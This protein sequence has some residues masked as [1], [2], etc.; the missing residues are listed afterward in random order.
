MR[1]L[2]QTLS[3]ILVFSSMVVAWMTYNLS[4]TP[5]NGESYF[6]ASREIIPTGQ[7]I[8]PY[9][10]VSIGC[11]IVAIFFLILGYRDS[12]GSSTH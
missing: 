7:S 2:F 1:T 10:I 9:S 5:F 12:K 8:M 3:I 6:V 11:L 4:K